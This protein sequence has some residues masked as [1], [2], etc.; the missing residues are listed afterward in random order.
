MN[1]NKIFIDFKFGN[2]I[3]K[4]LDQKKPVILS[5][6]WNLFL[7][8]PKTKRDIVDPARGEWQEHA[9]VSVGYNKN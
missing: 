8:K 7:K 3:R 6:N 1:K 2:Y 5:F 4:F 9:V